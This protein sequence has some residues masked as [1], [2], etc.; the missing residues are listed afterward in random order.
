MPPNA[1]WIT[2]VIVLIGPQF[3][4]PSTRSATS[5]RGTDN[6]IATTECHTGVP[7]KSA[8]TAMRKTLAA[9]LPTHTQRSGK[10]PDIP[11]AD[12]NPLN[13]RT[14]TPHL[15]SS[16]AIPPATSIPTAGHMMSSRMSTRRAS[17]AISP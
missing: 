1:A 3:V 10:S 4:S 9:R 16:A 6:T 17:A 11:D 12:A 14:R 2:L 15:K 7:K 8:C 13:V 5:P